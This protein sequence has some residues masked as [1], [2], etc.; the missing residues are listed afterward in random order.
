MSSSRKQ[1]RLDAKT[2]IESLSVQPYPN[3]TKVY[4]EGSRPD[5]RVPMREISLADSLVGGTKETPILEPNEPIQVY[6]TSG[7]YT[8][9]NYDID[10]YQGLPKLRERW[11]EERCDTE[12]L[13][14][15]SSAYSQ[16]RL[17]D[18]TLDELRYGNLPTI[19]RAKQGQC[20]TQ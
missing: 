8:D 11:I 13:K 20:V 16:E 1:A 9:P 19:R 3:S 14:G 7:V 18:E 4:I 2:N 12:V 10:V 15:V 5:I 17:A 6:D